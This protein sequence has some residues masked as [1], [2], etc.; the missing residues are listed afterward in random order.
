MSPPRQLPSH[1]HMIGRVPQRATAR[2]SGTGTECYRGQPAAMRPY[3][4]A[5]GSPRFSP[6][7]PPPV[8]PPPSPTRVAPH[9]FSIDT[10]LLSIRSDDATLNSNAAAL[11]E[12]CSHCADRAV[13]GSARGRSAWLP[14]PQAAAA[15]PPPLPPLP[16]MDTDP[17]R[18][19]PPLLGHRLRRSALK[20]RR[21]PTTRFSNASAGVEALRRRAPLAGSGRRPTPGSPPDSARAP[22]DTGSPRFGRSRPP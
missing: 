1:Q 2:A 12:L 8:F 10:K 20:S 17:S 21:W 6:P 7:P 4:Y 15:P 22:Y 16:P 14:P 5:Y 18:P 3:A 11:R 9:V 19:P 13:D